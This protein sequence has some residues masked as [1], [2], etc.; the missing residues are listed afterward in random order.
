MKY[1]ITNK[2]GEKETV[3]K[4]GLPKFSSTFNSMVKKLKIGEQ[5]YDIT[6]M[7][8]IKRIE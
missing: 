7:V 6:T 8:N 1:E 3:E 5:M 4:E 2:K